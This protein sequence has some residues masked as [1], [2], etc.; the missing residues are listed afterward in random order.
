MNLLHVVSAQA[1]FEANPPSLNSRSRG[2][3]ASP[4]LPGA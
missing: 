1:G 2:N 3:S 4:T